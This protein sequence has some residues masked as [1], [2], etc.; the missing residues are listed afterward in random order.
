MLTKTLK[1]AGDYDTIW[2]DLNTRPHFFFQLKTCSDF[3]LI[4]ANNTGQ[5][6]PYASNEIAIGVK[7]N[8]RTELRQGINGTVIG[9][10]DTVG[11][12]DCTKHRNFWFSVKNNYT[13]FGTGT[14]LYEDRLLRVYFS[15]VGWTT[16]A[17][18]FRSMS[19]TG[20]ELQIG[21]FEGKKLRL[22]MYV[23]NDIYI[24]NQDTLVC[25]I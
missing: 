18:G 23:K 12:L 1:T 14:K 17:I 2:M 19:S 22:H 3:F 11:V 25:P 10:A 9:E 15:D 7:G 6:D 13:E 8:K 21:T 4:A 24:Y 5:T 16:K 20:A